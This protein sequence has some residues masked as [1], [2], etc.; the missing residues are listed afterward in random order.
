MLTVSATLTLL[1]SV[2]NVRLNDGEADNG[3][4]SCPSAEQALTGST[5]SRFCGR[6]LT[7]RTRER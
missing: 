2:E 7:P 4:I 1:P 5:E 6:L 3:S